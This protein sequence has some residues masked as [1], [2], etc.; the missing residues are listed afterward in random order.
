MRITSPNMDFTSDLHSLSMVV[1][2]RRCIAAPSNVKITVLDSLVGCGISI[3]TVARAEPACSLATKRVV[4]NGR[5]MA[6]RVN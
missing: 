2:T 4:Q 3:S 5:T 6:S 1:S